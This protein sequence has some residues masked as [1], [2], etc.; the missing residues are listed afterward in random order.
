MTM[1]AIEDAERLVPWIAANA[2][3]V[4]FD[5]GIELAVLR[6]LGAPLPP[7]LAAD[8]PLLRW[9][10]TD[11]PAMPLLDARLDPPTHRHLRCDR[12]GNSGKDRAYSELWVP[13]GRSVV[14]VACC[15]TCVLTLDRPYGTH[16]LV[17]ADHP[18]DREG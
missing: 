16:S 8:T 7:E 12:C 15:S 14:V 6:A 1:A 3:A 13:A 2:D 11:L 10:N 18:Y 17:W 4:A 5:E 9:A